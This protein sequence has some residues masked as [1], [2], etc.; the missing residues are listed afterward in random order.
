[1]SIRRLP[2]NEDLALSASLTRLHSGRSA[3]AAESARLEIV[4]WATNRGFK[5]HLLRHPPSSSAQR[6]GGIVPMASCFGGLSVNC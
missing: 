5:S 4:C 3:R 2:L 1:V 6:E